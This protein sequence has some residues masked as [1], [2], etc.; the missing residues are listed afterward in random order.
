VS[1]CVCLVCLV[2]C[3]SFCNMCW[4]G[5]VWSVGCGVLGL[6]CFVR[7]ARVFFC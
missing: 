3:V 6:L 4:I 7:S 2:V 5:C 1:L